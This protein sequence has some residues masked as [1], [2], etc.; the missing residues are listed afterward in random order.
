MTNLIGLMQTKRIRIKTLLGAVAALCV[1]GFILYDT[2][3]YRAAMERAY[4]NEA[5][6]T[7]ISRDTSS[8]LELTRRCRNDEF[9]DSNFRPTPLARDCVF[10]AMPKIATWVGATGIARIASEL[11][12][13][14][15]KDSELREA[16]V[17]MIDRARHSLLTTEK[18]W[19]DR[20]VQVAKANNN[21]FFLR[22][23][24]GIQDLDSLSQA[25]IKAL[26]RAELSVIAPEVYRKQAKFAL[27]YY[28]PAP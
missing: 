2:A 23:I 1:F 15:P 3:D 13:A 5:A 12:V 18:Q 20:V 11:L 8:D 21:S 22:H 28:K 6:L 4:G 7:A 24:H 10:D 9:I 14:S 25:K 17:Q 27:D 26:E 16:T 19:D